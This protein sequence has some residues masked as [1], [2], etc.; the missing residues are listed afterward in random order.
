MHCKTAPADAGPCGDGAGRLNCFALVTYIPPPLGDFLDR[1]REELV[2]GCGLHSHLSI[3]PPRPLAGSEEAAIEQICDHTRRVS[4]VEVEATHVAVFPKTQVIY[5]EVGRGR[6]ELLHMHHIL[7]DRYLEYSEPYQYH[8]HI[9]LAQEIDPQLVPALYDL[10]IHRWREFPRKRAFPM[11][12]LTF[13]RN[14]PGNQWVDLAVCPL[15]SEA[16]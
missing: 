12:R 6:E 11:N 14:A 4:P 10:A 5:L 15:K 8:P 9:T 7:N 16:E 13:V 3:L 2:P 1:L